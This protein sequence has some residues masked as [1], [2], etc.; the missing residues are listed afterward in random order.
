MEGLPPLQVHLGA[1]SQPQVRPAP[2]QLLQRHPPPPAAPQRPR[3]PAPAALPASGTLQRPVA[4]QP[5]GGR[6]CGDGEGGRGAEGHPEEEGPQA[7]GAGG[8]GEE[9][10]WSVRCQT[11]P[12]SIRIEEAE[13]EAPQN[14]PAPVARTS[15]PCGRERRGGDAF[16]AGVRG[17]RVAGGGVA[18]ELPGER[19]AADA[20]QRV[21]PGGAEFLG[22]DPAAQE[23]GGAVDGPQRH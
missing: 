16:G 18:G 21:R 19:A 10:G 2:P 17:V 22:D 12:P 1:R 15:L 5:R 7:E 9:G 20:E 11:H 3:P 6:A 13:R 14:T 23:A 4:L 8:Q